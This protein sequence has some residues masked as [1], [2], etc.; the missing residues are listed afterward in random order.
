MS[1]SARTGQTPYFSFSTRP[2]IISIYF[3]AS[4]GSFLPLARI[5]SALS[6]MSS[7]ITSLF[8]CTSH[9]FSTTVAVCI[10]SIITLLSPFSIFSLNSFSVTAAIS[11]F[12][13]SIFPHALY[14]PWIILNTSISFPKYSLFSPTTFSRI[15]A[16]TSLPKSPTEFFTTSIVAK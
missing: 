14:T 11:L 8:L 3:L 13:L 6:S 4:S 2:S 10:A 7:P 16:S 1:S 15:F 12:I 5:F 9:L